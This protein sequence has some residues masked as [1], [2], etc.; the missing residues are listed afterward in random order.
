MKAKLQQPL[1]NA[2]PKEFYLKRKSRLLVNVLRLENESKDNKIFERLN[3]R[4][5]RTCKQL[6]ENANMNLGLNYNIEKL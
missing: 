2:R 3:S 6:I 4:I 1:I 5:I